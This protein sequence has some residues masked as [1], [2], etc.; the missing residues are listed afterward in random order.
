MAC[1]EYRPSGVP[2]RGNNYLRKSLIEMKD[3]LLMDAWLEAI[4]KIE[5]Y[6]E[7]YNLGGIVQP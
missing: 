4:N 2:F 6:R 1:V 7:E 3:T 5:Y